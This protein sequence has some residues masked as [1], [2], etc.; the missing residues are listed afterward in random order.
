MYAF[1]Y[2]V[3][4]GDLQCTDTEIEVD[5][6]R[7]AGTRIQSRSF[8]PATGRHSAPFSHGYTPYPVNLPAQEQTIQ[9]FG[10]FNP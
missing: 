1:L 5:P 8:P 4:F 10:Q 9:V 6:L 3:S 7:W 2:D